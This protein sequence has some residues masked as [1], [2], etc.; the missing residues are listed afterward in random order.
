MTDINNPVNIIGANS[1]LNDLEIESNTDLRLLEKEVVNGVSTIQEEETNIMEDFNNEM[2]SIERKIA[3][4]SISRSST[5]RALSPKNETDALSK[6][7]DE[8]FNET[9]DIDKEK[10]FNPVGFDKPKRINIDSPMSS[11]EDNDYKLPE[12]ESINCDY[13]EPRDKQLQRMTL[14]ERKQ[15]KINSVFKDISPENMDFDMD[16]EREEDDKIALIEQI[17]MLK[18]TLEDEDI[19]VSNVPKVSK[20]TSMHDIQNVYKILRLK[21]DRKR[22]TDFAEE[23]ILAGALGMEYLFNGEREWWGRKPDLTD[24]NQTVKTK[25]RRMRFETSSFVQSIMQEYKTPPYMRL[26]L[27]LIPSMFLYSRNRRISKND[28]IADDIAEQEYKNAISSMND[29]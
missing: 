15:E 2:K 19:D 17:D 25:L 12:K 29:F 9:S 24:W 1:I 10:K 16:K 14:E 13:F 4:V 6:L 23:I 28:N 20:D 3:K 7:E 5:P 22:H 26:L 18:I 11:Y 21:N 8:L 27:E